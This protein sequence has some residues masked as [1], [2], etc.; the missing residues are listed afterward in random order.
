M[1]AVVPATAILLAAGLSSRMGTP[2]PLLDWCGRPLVAYQV[3]QLR[4]AGAEP[5]LVVT[6]HAAAAV[7]AALAGQC[8]RL[9]RNTAYH[10]GRATSVRAAALALADTAAPLVLLNVDQPRH[11]VTIRRLIEAHAA[12][13]GLITVLVH[14]GRRG[15]PAVL[16]GA[17]LPELRGL[18]E[19]GEGL[20]AVMRRHAAER[21]EIPVA[22]DEVLLD[23]NDP[24]AYARAL[25]G[26]SC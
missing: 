1:P 16:S 23:L 3:S 4:E 13:G 17:L 25:A 12:H 18:S 9:V 7:E 21:V 15:H 6:G 5:V 11:A 19:E 2:K 20:R 26:W 22:S 24:A 8:V 14:A 10:E